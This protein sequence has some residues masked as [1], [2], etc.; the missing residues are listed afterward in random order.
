MLLLNY[1]VE[2]RLRRKI[3]A[4][5]HM[6]AEANPGHYFAVGASA[7]HCIAS[8]AV[9][10]GHRGDF[11]AVLDFACG[12]GRVTRWLRAAFPD[13]RVV[14]SDLRRDSLEWIAANLGAEPWPS[15]EDIGSL[16]PPMPFDL[17][18]CG[19]LV[20]HLP[21]AAAAGLLA[22]FARWL[23]PNGLAVVST[24]G[25]R[26]LENQR[27]GKAKY[28]PPELFARVAAGYE[29]GGYGYVDYP[30]RTGIGVSV[31]S[32]AWLARTVLGVERA[33][34]VALAEAAWDNHHDIV[35]IQRVG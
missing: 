26:T 4:G 23:A 20:T 5:D 13:A 21:E 24:H 3:M 10:A 27:G 34:L 11:A 8:V 15:A 2:A 18:W 1:A 16:R 28:L 19:S 25:R 30:G 14:A 32:P 22:A 6:Y 29:A 31:C 17:I 35:A 33:R 12:S 7:M 9:A